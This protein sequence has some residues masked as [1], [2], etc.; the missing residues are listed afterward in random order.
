VRADESRTS[1]DEGS[2]RQNASR[3]AF[4]EP[5][6]AVSAADAGGRATAMKWAIAIIALI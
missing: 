6:N 2:A 1:G 4:P 5:A 3:E